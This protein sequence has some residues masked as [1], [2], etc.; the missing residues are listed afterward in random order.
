MTLYE[1]LQAN[2][3]TLLEIDPVNRKARVHPKDAP[4]Y[5]SRDIRDLPEG[6]PLP[7]NLSG[8]EYVDIPPDVH[9]EEEGL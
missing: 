4:P 5:T 2:N 8:A 3:Y 9:D 1:W 6:K 7:L